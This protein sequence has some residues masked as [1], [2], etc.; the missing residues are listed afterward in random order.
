MN[1]HRLQATS[2]KLSA[3][4]WRHRVVA[5]L[6]IVVAV[7]GVEFYALKL[8]QAQAA[9]TIANSTRFISGWSGYDMNV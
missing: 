3:T 2:H 5:A 1:F 6:L 7:F 4:L 9:Y 8:P